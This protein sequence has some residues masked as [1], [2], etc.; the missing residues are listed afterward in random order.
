MYA[1]GGSS[2]HIEQNGK[3]MSWKM[4]KSGLGAIILLSVKMGAFLGNVVPNCW[5]PAIVCSKENYPWLIKKKVLYST[6]IKFY[7]D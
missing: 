7:M 4:E 2:Y 3:A 6:E 5:F 1:Y